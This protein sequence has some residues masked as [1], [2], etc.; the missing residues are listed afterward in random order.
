MERTNANRRPARAHRRVVAAMAVAASV[1]GLLIGQAQAAQH[2]AEK[3]KGDITIKLHPVTDKGVDEKTEAGAA[4][5]TAPPRGGVGVSLELSGL[6]QGN[7]YV[8]IHQ[9]G[10]CAPGKVGDKVIA[11]GS[12]GPIFLPEGASVVQSDNFKAYTKNR[13]NMRIGADGTGDFQYFINGIT[14]DQLGGRTIVIKGGGA[15]GTQ[16]IDPL[17]VLHGAVACGVIPKNP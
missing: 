2:D 1:A 17:V 12:A 9:G 8:D 16:E 10:S 7:H 4:T 13:A 3:G 14:L 5:F 15:E 6:L 11:A